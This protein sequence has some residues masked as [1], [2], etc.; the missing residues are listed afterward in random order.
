MKIC[1]YADTKNIHTQRWTEYLKSKGHL[2][3]LISDFPLT[4]SQ[5]KNYDLQVSSNIIGIRFIQ[6]IAKLKKILSE[7]KP[8]IF[9]AHSITT[10]GSFASLGNYHPFIL[11][12]WGSDIFITPKKSF[13]NFLWV[14]HALKKADLVTT[15]SNQLKEEVLSLIKTKKVEIVP[16]GVDVEI[17][18]PSQKK[19][20]EGIHI[21]FIKHLEEIYGPEYLIRAM[22]KVI[23]KY[24]ET[25]LEMVGEGSQLN[26]LKE[27]AEK[28]NMQ[29][30]ILFKG[31]FPH[32]EIPSILNS[33]DIF[34]MPSIWESFGVSALEAQ[35]MQ[36]PVIATR[37]GG[38]PEVVIDNET[39]I[40]VEPQ[41][42]EQ[43]SQAII[44]LIEDKQL[45]LEMGKKGRQFVQEKYNWQKNAQKMEDLYYEI[46]RWLPS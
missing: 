25:K 39:G 1:Y 14:K 33:I 21:G 35:A 13:Q 27:L 9:H 5:F 42:V 40:L 31:Y 12:A 28:L 16:F 4:S 38:I 2:I 45:R 34:V 46:S 43:I 30:N 6:R 37:V 32:Q 10:Y 23:E 20:N 3:Y 26:Y 24:P 29:Q 36:V 22:K 8:E 41:N 19:K 7:I 17:F 44:K 11:T 15:S 18:S